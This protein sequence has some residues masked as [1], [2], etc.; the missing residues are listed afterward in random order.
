MLTL[1]LSCCLYLPLYLIALVAQYFPL[2]VLADVIDGITS[3][4][5]KLLLR[6]GVLPP[7]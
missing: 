5:E 4:I 2:D 7:V 3:L 1:I 6:A